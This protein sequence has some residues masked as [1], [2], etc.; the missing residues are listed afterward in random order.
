MPHIDKRLAAMH[1]A[2]TE[3]A[4]LICEL[5]RERDRAKLL[6][7]DQELVIKRLR[8]ELAKQEEMVE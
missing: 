6:A 5:R 8:A 7:A 2:L 1:H 3:C 4:D